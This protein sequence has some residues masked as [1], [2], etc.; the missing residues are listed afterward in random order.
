MA[1][2]S[3]NK[4]FWARFVYF[5][6]LLATAISLTSC[7]G[8]YFFPM[9]EQVLTP[10][11]FG[12]R[13]DDVW[14]DVD[15]NIKLHGWYLHTQQK[16]KAAILFFHGN[17]ENISTH[18]ASVQWLPQ[19]GYDVYLFDYRGYG[20]SQ[21]EPTVELVVTDAVT[22]IDAV[23][24]RL[25]V[26]PEQLIL[27]GQSLGGAIALNAAQQTRLK[28]Q[29][30][31]VVVDSTFS[32]F[33]GIA[34]EKLGEFWLTW[35]LQ[36]PLSYSFTNEYPPM[37]AAA[38]LKGVPLLV[39]HGDSDNIIPWHHGKFIYDA[40]SEPK[41]LWTINDGRHIDSMLRPDVRERFVR[42]LDSL[43]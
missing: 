11:R 6:V 24:K 39:I 4:T 35:P 40:A 31:G 7:N 26:K 42:Y 32:S 21:G 25:G 3:M 30:A 27:F 28:Y 41:Q 2:W 38:A 22:V 1:I 20:L 19:Y 12:L 33:R 43:L 17:A 10:A 18:I 29:F 8:L 23:V 36:W 37:E 15:A 13:F 16:P 9:K 14:V 5:L 34:R